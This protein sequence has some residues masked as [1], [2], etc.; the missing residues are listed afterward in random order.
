MTK[1]NFISKKLRKIILS[2]NTSIENYFNLLKTF[3]HNF[4]KFKINNNS[5]VFIAI[6]VSI[7]FILSY[8]L[9]PTTYNKEN[10]KQNIKNQILKKDNIDIKFNNKITY[11]LLPRPHFTTKKLSI[12]R[13]DK[14]IGEVGKF[15]A[16]ISIDK[17]FFFQ[18]YELKDL[19]LNKSD[20]NIKKD[21]LVFFKNLLETEASKNKI[22]F[23][24]SNIFFQSYDDEVLFINKIKDGKFFYDSNNLENI[25]FADN[26]IFNIPYKLRIKNNKFDKKIYTNLQSKKIRLNLKNQIDYG[27]LVKNGILD[28]L[29]VNKK[30][31]VDY[32]IKKNSLNYSSENNKNT[33][34]GRMDFKPFYLN[35]SFNYD[36]L[37]FKNIL[38][39]DSIVIDIIKSEIF[40]NKNLNAN[41]N[42][43][44][45]DIINFAEL[46]NLALKISVLEGDLS[47]SDSTISWK[48][49]VKIKL[50]E[51]IFIYGDDGINLIGKIILDFKNLDN[52]YKSFQ[53]NKN[54]RKKI[55][56]LEFDFIYNLSQKKI[57]L[58]NTKIDNANNQGLDKFI[59]NFNN[60]RKNIFNK[61]T[62]KNFISNFFDAYA[63]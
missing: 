36:G 39:Q 17:L 34:Y 49:D 4:K 41:L 62:F 15:R 56:S 9:I 42:L 33:Y 53:I 22:I 1:Q 14:P 52:F 18:N 58:D 45:K 23:K 12:L 8:F 27:S 40:N 28:I 24:D 63:G 51:S 32:E 47:L 60:S 44:V 55:S 46:N 6:G 38:K 13:N 57:T 43:N 10:I 11:A 35:S 29:F 48:N 16:F 25:F 5:K 7:I 20:F 31:S 21:D 2:T 50:N 19:V 30:T 26:E 54:N 3:L 59:S 37:S 61:I